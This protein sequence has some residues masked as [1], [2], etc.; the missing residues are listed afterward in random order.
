MLLQSVRLSSKVPGSSTGTR[1][2]SAALKRDLSA[3]RLP[4]A[5]R[6]AENGFR[7]AS[8]SISPSARPVYHLSSLLPCTSSRQSFYRPEPKERS[9]TH[10]QRTTSCL[11]CSYR[12][13]VLPA[14]RERLDE[15]AQRAQ[16]KVRAFPRSRFL[17]TRGRTPGRRSMRP[18]SPGT[19]TGTRCLLGQLMEPTAGCPTRVIDSTLRCRSGHPGQ[20]RRYRRCPRGGSAQCPRLMVQPASRL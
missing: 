4:N 3:T 11:F 12:L 10:C 5:V 7:C 16:R 14:S 13:E 9:L 6:P 1:N 20:C 17:P 2:P 8:P 15:T 19:L 18:R